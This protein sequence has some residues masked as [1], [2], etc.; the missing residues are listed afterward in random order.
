MKNEKFSKLI[1]DPSKIKKML[2]EC[3]NSIISL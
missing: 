2:N 3:R 1:E